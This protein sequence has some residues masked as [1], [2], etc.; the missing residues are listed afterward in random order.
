M[1]KKSTFYRQ[2]RVVC[3]IAPSFLQ[4]TIK[5]VHN[6][7]ASHGCHLPKQQNT[8]AK[9]TNQFN[10]KPR[11]KK[12][13]N[14]HVHDVVVWTIFICRMIQGIRKYPRI[15]KQNKQ[16]QNVITVCP[17]KKTPCKIVQ[18]LSSLWERGGGG[19]T[20]HSCY[21]RDIALFVL[22]VQHGPLDK[23]LLLRSS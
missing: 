19:R 16:E 13:K 2:P 21:I 7:L 12:T 4:P 8:R 11:N 22:Q 15:K 10:K 6:L 1:K 3:V 14:A 17:T 9:K 20:L 5:A 23:K 18:H